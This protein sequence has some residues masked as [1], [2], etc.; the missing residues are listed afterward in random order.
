MIA[1]MR[2]SF[3]SKNV[4][5]FVSNLLIGKG[6]LESLA[7]EIKVK[8]ADKWDGKDAQPYVEEPYDE[9]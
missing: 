8:K 5:E 7:S 6:G 3:S 4:N 9:L 1:T 2:S